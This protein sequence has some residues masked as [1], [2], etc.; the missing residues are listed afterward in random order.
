MNLKYFVNVQ[1][2]EELRKQ[3]K[4]L[5][6]KHHPDRGG[7]EKDMVAINVEY[8]WIKD[9]LN[10][11]NSSYQDKTASQK[12][13]WEN[14]DEQLRAKIQSL[15]DFRISAKI[16]ICGTWI[17]L[18]DT[19]KEEK[20]VYKAKG[21]RWAPTKKMWYWHPEGYVRKSRKT[22]DMDYIRVMHGSVTVQGKSKIYL[23]DEK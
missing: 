6:F 10:L 14:F 9:N 21:F 22:F 15:V 3:F 13:E 19:L 11:A 23:E 8:D 17:W 18:S 5:V 4:E 16:E 1:S 2:I 7:N 12:E 20:E